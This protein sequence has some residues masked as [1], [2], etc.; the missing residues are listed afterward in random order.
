M[1]RAKYYKKMTWLAAATTGAC[2]ALGVDC[3][4]AV[5]ASIGATFF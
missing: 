2:V 3:I 1:R 4:G 5:L